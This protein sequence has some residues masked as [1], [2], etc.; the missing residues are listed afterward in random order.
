MKIVDQQLSDTDRAVVL[1]EGK[2][3]VRGR[4]ERELE[5][6]GSSGT[7]LGA[8][9]RAWRRHRGMTVTEL[10]QQ[11]GFG[12]NG[13]GYISKIEHERIKRLG[14][15]QLGAIARALGMTRQDLQEQRLPEPQ[16]R[17]HPDKAVLDEAIFGCKALLRV[18]D[19]DEEKRLDR[20]RISVKLAEL[21]WERH[22]LTDEREERGLLLEEALRQIDQALTIFHDVA[23]GSYQEARHLRAK[24][25]HVRY[26][27]D[28]DAAITGCQALLQVHHPQERPLDWARTHVRLAQLYWDRAVQ[29]EEARERHGL[30]GQALESIDQALPWFRDR[31]P[32][33][34]TQAQRMRQD[35]EGAWEE[36]ARSSF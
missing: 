16:T 23:P 2:A 8:T 17:Q 26:R 3:R 29:S 14:E 24:I 5:P 7:G 28:L 10:A 27:N 36:A 22:L 31:A 33:S 18:Y 13:R 20:A 6:Q 4:K 9:I 19:Q 1:G 12:S 21:C 34:Y 15:E 30:L 25:E 11:A 35:V 32:V